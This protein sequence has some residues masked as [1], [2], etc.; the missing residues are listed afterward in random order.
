M[1]GDELKIYRPQVQQKDKGK[2]PVPSKVMK[3]EDVKPKNAEKKNQPSKP[4]ADQDEK[5]KKKE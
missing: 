5:P 4:K 1:S 2:N 3:L